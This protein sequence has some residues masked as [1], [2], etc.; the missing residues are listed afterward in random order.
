MT[1]CTLRPVNRTNLSAVLDMKVSEAQQRFVAPNILSLAE[2]AAMPEMRPRALYAEDTLVGFAMYGFDEEENAYC[3][4]RLMIDPAYQG[5]G[6]GREAL[7]LMVDEIQ[8]AAPERR[9]IYISFIPDNTVAK[10]LY[11]RF[12][13]VPDGREVDGEIVY[14]F[15]F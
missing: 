1:T 9:I 6:Y 8:A 11:E 3:I 7:R 15:D 4:D 2:A 14:R 5:K 12:G 10:S 13:F